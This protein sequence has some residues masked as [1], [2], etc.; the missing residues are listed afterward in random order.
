MMAGYGGRGVESCLGVAREGGRAEGAA[1]FR[2]AVTRRGTSSMPSLSS[3]Q[4]KSVWSRSETDDACSSN[5]SN[6]RDGVH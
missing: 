5:A 3:D 1:R 6:E 2:P 4:S